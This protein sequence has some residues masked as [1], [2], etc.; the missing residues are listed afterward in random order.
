MLDDEAKL[1]NFPAKKDKVPVLTLYYS[2]C[3]MMR[4]KRTTY[5]AS[6]A[7]DEVAELSRDIKQI[8]QHLQKENRKKDKLIDEYAKLIHGLK[9]DYQSV[10]AEKNN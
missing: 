3:K 7:D 10:I 1:L 8:I 9:R 6:A 5:V 4:V 2:N